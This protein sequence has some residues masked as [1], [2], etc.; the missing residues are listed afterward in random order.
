MEVSIC[1]LLCFHALLSACLSVFLSVF[2][3]ITLAQAFPASLSVRQ[4]ILSDMF[5]LS[6]YCMSTFVNWQKNKFTFILEKSYSCIKYPKNHFG[7][8]RLDI[9]VKRINSYLFSVE[10]VFSVSVAQV[11][12][13]T[14]T[15]LFILPLGC[16]FGGKI[17]LCG[18][19]G[20]LHSPCNVMFMCWVFG[21]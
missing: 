18:I 4:R 7:N 3:C 9:I 17:C 6:H 8:M 11:N 12:P 16:I 1:D 10:F 21:F 20:A 2:Q 15:L 19:R 13:F 5:P 14:G